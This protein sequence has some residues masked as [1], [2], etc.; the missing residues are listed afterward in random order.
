MYYVIDD[1]MY[2]AFNILKNF[3]IKNLK[4]WIIITINSEID[5]IFDIYKKLG[6]LT[7][8]NESK[9]R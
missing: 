3:T 1:S 4:N 7:I 9:N 5:N 8:S 6:M 2:Q